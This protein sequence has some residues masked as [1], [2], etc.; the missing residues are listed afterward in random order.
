MGT[1]TSNDP[2]DITITTLP[3]DHESLLLFIRSMTPKSLMSDAAI[4]YAPSVAELGNVN[5][6]S[7]KRI[8]GA[9]LKISLTWK[10]G[11]EG[12]RKKMI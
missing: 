5:A 8:Q 6:T 2:N 10:L 12:E 7:G 3:R 4:L 1:A 11:F 9:I